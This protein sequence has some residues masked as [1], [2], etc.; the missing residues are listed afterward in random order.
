MKATY[1]KGCS[2]LQ[3]NLQEFEG[4]GVVDLSEANQLMKYI[5]EAHAQEYY[6]LFPH[7]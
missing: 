1:S 3:P 7:N 4:P 6:F 5:P 2:N